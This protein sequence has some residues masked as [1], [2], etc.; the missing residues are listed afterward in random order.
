MQETTKESEPKT[1]KYEYEVVIAES[2]TFI[3]TT[4]EQSSQKEAE[5]KSSDLEFKVYFSKDDQPKTSN[6]SRASTVK[7]STADSKLDFTFQKVSDKISTYRNLSTLLLK[8]PN[9]KDGAENNNRLFVGVNSATI[10]EAQRQ[11]ICLDLLL[12][13]IRSG[14]PNTIPQIQCKI[15]YP[16]F[17]KNYYCQSFSSF[18]ENHKFDIRARMVGYPL[19]LDDTPEKKEKFYEFKLLLAL[20]TPVFRT[21]MQLFEVRIRLR[22]D[23]ISEMSSQTD[24]C[25]YTGCY[26]TSVK[27]VSN[28]FE[29]SGRIET[30]ISCVTEK[31]STPMSFKP[32]SKLPSQDSTWSYNLQIPLNLTTHIIDQNF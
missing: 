8:F 5:K 16:N 31:I 14:V 9:S 29:L 19:E 30:P 13:V 2:N 26:Q 23:I 28:M 18:D 6:Q 21:K 24:P 22:E 17:F 25:K 10:E 27:S 11:Y 4:S 20:H 3:P 12:G 7:T 1:N 32:C 15:C